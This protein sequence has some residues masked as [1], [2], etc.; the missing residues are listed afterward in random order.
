MGARKLREYNN[1]V[2]LRKVR[3]HGKRKKTN[4]PI[5][6]LLIVLLIGIV[7]FT[8]NKEQKDN[9]E[10]KEFVKESLKEKTN[11]QK[12]L[13]LGKITDNQ[14]KEIF[15]FT[16]IEVKDYNLMLENFFIYHALTRHGNINQEQKRGQIAINA[17]DFEKTSEIFKNPEIILP[18]EAKQT[19]KLIQYEKTIKDMRYIFVVEIRRAKR[20]IMAKTLYKR[21]DFK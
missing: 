11:K 3:G 18:L 7:V 10:I 21:R 5:L 8:N 15:E 2:E 1:Y 14:A 13:D 20:E 19:N 9:K 4:L 12:K 16:G 17:S 6:V